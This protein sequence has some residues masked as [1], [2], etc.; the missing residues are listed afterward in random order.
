MSR[1]L[2]PYQGMH[3]GEPILVCGLGPSVREFKPPPGLVT[4][5]VNDCDRFFAPT[6]LFCCDPLK[7]FLPERRA[8]IEGSGAK[9]IFKYPSKGKQGEADREAL[10]GKDVV[11]I[12]EMGV[13]SGRALDG[14]L[15]YH[16][17]SVYPAIILACW[18]GAGRIGV[19]GCDLD[20]RDQ[21]QHA[22]RSYKKSMS[23][24]YALTA[25]CGSL[26]QQGHD[27]RN[28]S[29]I[30]R[31]EIPRADLH[32]LVTGEEGCKERLCRIETRST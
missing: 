10:A 4:I 9:L 2:L 16:A 3:L 21:P 32:W 14:K 23:I 19:L 12:E 22:L 20:F 15:H 29:P 5:G 18:F 25:L 30:G 1:A 17:T 27:V 31:L 28:I 24:V 6:Y 13:R 7:R 8:W 11:W 26:A